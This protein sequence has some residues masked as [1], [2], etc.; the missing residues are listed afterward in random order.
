[1]TKKVWGFFIVVFLVFIMLFSGCELLVPSVTYEA[2]TTKIMYDISYGYTVNSSGTGVYEIIYWCDT[3]EVS[4]GTIK[5]IPLYQHDYE[6]K[7]FENNTVLYW[8][9]SG[10]D[11]QRFDLGISAQVNVTGFLVADLNGKEALTISEIALQYPQI[12]T[13]FTR[14]QGNETARYIDPFDPDIASIAHIAWDNAKT[15]NSFLVAKSLFVWLK[16]NIMYQTHPLE[17]GVRPAS[18]TLD[19]KKGDCDDLSFLYVSL[20]RAVGIPARFIRGYLLTETSNSTVLATAHAWAEVFVGGPESLEGWIPVECACC[21]SSI[22]ID[23]NQNFGVENAYHLRLFTDNG[24]NESLSFTFVGISY[25]Y[26]PNRAIMLHPF[27]EI[28][29]FRKLQSKE[30]VITSENLRYYE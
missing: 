25:T 21:T 2:S 9:I 24:N 19:K 11:E 20:C 26:G 17:G 3:P 23:I 12:V 7:I 4:I 27:A 5:Y 18:V 8:N 14:V 13:Q 15:N 6:P 28:R 22:E 16:Q 10:R 1:M 30:L 29:N